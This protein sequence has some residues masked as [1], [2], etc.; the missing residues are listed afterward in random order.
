MGKP[1][2]VDEYL[3]AFPEDARE[4][5]LEL[6]ALSRTQVSE[7]S[8]ALKWGSPAY[9]LDGTIM[10]VFAGYRQHAN[11]VFTPSTRAAFAD[12]LT[13]FRTG[14][15]SVQLPYKQPVPAELLGRMI[16]Y[17][18]REFRDDGVLWM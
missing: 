1:K 8:E 15:G 4:V 6:R 10:F 7:A 12:E 13:D 18:I 9:S 2:T 11:F 14:K 5:L 17:R 16:A 3:A